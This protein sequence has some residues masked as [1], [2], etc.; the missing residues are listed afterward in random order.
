MLKSVMSMQICRCEIGSKFFGLRSPDRIDRSP[1]R[2]QERSPNLYRSSANSVGLSH[3]PGPRSLGHR[4]RG[5]SLRSVLFFLLRPESVLTAV[6][7]RGV[8]DDA[9]LDR[10][11]RL[12]VRARE[13]GPEE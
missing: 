1:D 4:D 12:R 2:F 7:P 8:D 9:T 13:P 6:S 3:P 10:C 5:S 11:V